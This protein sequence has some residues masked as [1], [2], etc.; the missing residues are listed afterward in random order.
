M[1]GH[2][3]WSTIK[4]KKA[5]QD[6]KRGKLFTK[7]IRAITSAARHGGGD[8][9]ANP[10]LRLAMDKAGA[11]NMP[12]DTVERAIKRG[13]GELEG[14]HYEE[15]TY[16]G[17]GPGGVAIMVEVLTDNRNRTVAELRNIFTKANGNLGQ[18]GCVA[19]MFDSRGQVIIDKSDVA[20]EDDLLMVAVESGADDMQEEGDQFVLTCSPESLEDLKKALREAELPIAES[21]LTR[22]PQNTVEVNGKEAD[23]VLRLLEALEDQDDVQQVYANCDFSGETLAELG[24]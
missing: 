11:A 5:A 17:Y 21:E 2:S 23:Q 7:L 14:V 1:S 12:K 3:K 22:I 8:P 6:A 24:R 18:D 19:W 16:E 13:T 15:N 20:D 4:H 9:D 10:A